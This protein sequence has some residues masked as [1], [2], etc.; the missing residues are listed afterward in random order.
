[1][2]LGSETGSMVNHLYSRMTLDEPA[3]YVGMPATLLSWTDRHPGTVIEVN[4]DKRYI[5]VQEDDYRRVDG[6]GMSEDQDYEYIQNLNG[7]TY[8][9]R[10]T[11]HGEW[12]MHCINPE[13]KRLV[14]SRGRGLYLGKRER[15][16]DFS[17]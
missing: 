13:T 9:Y 7:S 11:K 16:Y 12:V 1:M 5:V 10:K 15:Y 17:F 4:M 3:P 6:H 14:Q 8:I 2:K